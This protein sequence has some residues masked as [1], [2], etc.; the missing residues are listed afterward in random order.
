[1]AP[2]ST[3]NRHHERARQ[4]VFK[5]FLLFMFALVVPI[6]G[7]AVF[8]ALQLRSIE[9]EVLDASIRTLSLVREV[10]DAAGERIELTLT[11][12]RR[13]PAL[14]PLLNMAYPVDSSLV[15]QVLDAHRTSFLSRVADPF[16]LDIFV[17]FSSPR[18][19]FTRDRLFFD[20]QRFYGPFFQVQGLNHDQ[21][22][23]VFSPSY[24]TGPQMFFYDIIYNGVERE[25]VELRYMLPPVTRIR[26]QGVVAALIDRQ[27]VSELVSG[28]VTAAGGVALIATSDGVLVVDT[29]TEQFLGLGPEILSAVPEEGTGGVLFGTW[30]EVPMAVVYERSPVF[31]WLIVVAQPRH[32][33]FAQSQRI[34]R[35][36]VFFLVLI[37]TIGVPVSLILAYRTSRPLITIGQILRD[38]VVK[39]TLEPALKRKTG[40]DVLSESV[41]ELSQR[42][43]SLRRLMEEQQPLVRQVI[44]DRLFRGDYPTENELLATLRH[45]EIDISAKTF[46]VFALLIDGYYDEA[47]DEVVYEFLVK[48]TIVKEL[49]NELLPLGSLVHGMN[50]NR[51]AAVVP[52]VSSTRESAH[53]VFED[54]LVRVRRTLTVHHSTPCFIVPGGMTNRLIE[55]P[56]LLRVAMLA[57]HSIGV[58]GQSAGNKQADAYYYPPDLETR[59]VNFTQAGRV[60]ELQILLDTVSNEN[61][62]KRNLSVSVLKGLADELEGTKH[63]I[64]SMVEVDSAGFWPKHALKLSTQDYVRAQLSGIHEI[65]LRVSQQEL[66]HHKHRRA[67]LEFVE[68]HY[69]EPSMG[70]KRLSAEFSLSEVYLSCLFR[71]IAGTTFSSF[72]EKLRME[73]AAKLLKTT[74]MNVE[75]VA[76][77]TGYASSDV[78]RR[79]FKRHFGVSPSAF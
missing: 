44:I 63:K 35:V 69:S 70:L 31:G 47:N 29:A 30:N 71:Q 78:F 76:R 11:S 24:Y 16:L 55:V 23:Q 61:L 36:F 54:A 13:D 32:I 67:I 12:I 57:M 1:M 40:Y 34:A 75:E 21:W 48:S 3:E 51:V 79:A 72:L 18:I 64:L 2:P 41:Y 43:V 10:V 14:H 56:E 25:V 5:S 50:L 6:F 60:D 4:L 33:F 52:I 39:T 49:L 22:I 15:V 59:I 37:V 46:G 7:G 53:S 58:D 73:E 26:S 28:Q 66:H 68:Q 65:A 62:S 45:Y 42:H 9:D 38:G 20:T 74:K 27:A 19:L 77:N 8:F 17:Y